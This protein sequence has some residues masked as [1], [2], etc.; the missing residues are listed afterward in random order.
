M[1]TTSNHMDFVKLWR[2]NRLALTFAKPLWAGNSG[3]GAQETSFVMS[4]V[5]ALEGKVVLGLCLAIENADQVQIFSEIC[6]HTDV[7]KCLRDNIPCLFDQPLQST[8]SLFD[9][10]ILHCTMGIHS[11]KDLYNYKK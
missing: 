3:H 4:K 5:Q 11:F 7:R 9:E 10:K 1:E 6:A 8:Q 2:V